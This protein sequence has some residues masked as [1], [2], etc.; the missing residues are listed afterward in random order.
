VQGQYS[1]PEC[2]QVPIFGEPDTTYAEHLIVCHVNQLTA[3]SKPLR[4]LRLI[5][6]NVLANGTFVCVNS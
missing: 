1:S 4:T 6:P 2:S 3:W 5:F